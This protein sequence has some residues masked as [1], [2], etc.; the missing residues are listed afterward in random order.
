LPAPVIAHIA[1]RL[2]IRAW[3]STA[4]EAWIESLPLSKERREA[5]RNYI[6]Q[7]GLWRGT[8]RAAASSSASNAGSGG[9]LALVLGPA[10]D[11]P[12]VTEGW[13]QPPQGGLV[14]AGTAQELDDLQAIG[15]DRWIQ[16]LQPPL[17]VAWEPGMETSTEHMALRK[18]VNK[19]AS[20]MGLVEVWLYRASQAGTQTPR[21]IDPATAEELWVDFSAPS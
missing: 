17:V 6:A 7:E 9:R 1:E 16:A 15:L 5:L 11:A 12:S 19:L 14:L 8:P 20:G 21:R 2:G 13:P 18:S 3:G 4:Q 10:G